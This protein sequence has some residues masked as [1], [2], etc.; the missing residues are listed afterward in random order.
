MYCWKITRGI[1]H[2]GFEGGESIGLSDSHLIEIKER[3]HIISC[4]TPVDSS[5]LEG[6]ATGIQFQLRNFKFVPLACPGYMGG[7]ILTQ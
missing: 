5:I 4:V 2:S 7:C 1:R 3:F 6:P